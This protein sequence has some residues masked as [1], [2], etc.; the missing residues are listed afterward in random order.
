MS[1]LGLLRRRPHEHTGFRLYGAAVAAARD[2]A[3]YAGLAVPD[4]TAGRFEM[5]ALHAALLIRRLRGFA[6]AEGDAL[7]QAVFDAMFAD[8]DVTLREMGVGDLSVGKK[9]KSLWEGFHGRA[10]AYGAALDAEDA[11][12]LT[13]A[14]ARNVWAGGE[15]PP[16]AAEALAARAEAIARRL[17]GVEAA[18]FAAGEAPFA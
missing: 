17:A 11:A 6:T 1:L 13:A 2:P 3:L 8:M 14:L 18:R 12:A 15:A 10:E 16:G 7:G 4:T 9:V 5:I